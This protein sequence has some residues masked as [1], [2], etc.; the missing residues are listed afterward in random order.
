MATRGLHLRNG[1][2][3]ERRIDRGRGGHP[4]ALPTNHMNFL[5]TAEGRKS[6]QADDRVSRAMAGR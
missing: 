4:P 5:L 6:D 1:E 2:F 3:K